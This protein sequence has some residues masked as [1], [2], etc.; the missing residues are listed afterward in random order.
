MRPHAAL[1]EASPKEQ[2]EG[3][4][5][6]DTLTVSSRTTPRNK[7]TSK[8]SP[9]SPDDAALPRHAHRQRRGTYAG[10][11]GHLGGELKTTNLRRKANRLV[12]DSHEGGATATV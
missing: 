5:Y 7:N 9:L 12:T 2:G 6:T 10:I 3:R 11:V 1:P 8:T 4:S